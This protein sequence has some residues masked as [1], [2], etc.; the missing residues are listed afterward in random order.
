ML[1]KMDIEKAYDTLQWDIILATLVKMHFSSIWIAYIKACLYSTS[2]SIIVN[3][4]RTDLFHPSRG[5]RQGDPL[6]PYLFILVAQNLSAILNYTRQLNLIHGFSNNLSINFNHLM[7]VDDLII[8]TT[9][10]RKSA[11]NIN[12]YLNLH[13]QLAKSQT[14]INLRFL[15]QL[16]QHKIFN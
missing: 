13:S 2:F 16:V 12:F 10:S 9:A 4:S 8:I 7:Y 14:K 11:R 6:S 5:V 1:I 3:G 15:F